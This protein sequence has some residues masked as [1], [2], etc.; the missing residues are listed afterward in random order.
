V[1]E[2][3]TDVGLDFRAHGFQGGDA[4]PGLYDVM[5]TATTA[6]VVTGGGRAMT[7]TSKARRLVREAM[8]LL[9]QGQTAESRAAHL[10]SLTFNA[11]A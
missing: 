10:A 11:S 6:A 9:V 7:L 3:L 5:R 8:F 4:R 1:D 2:D